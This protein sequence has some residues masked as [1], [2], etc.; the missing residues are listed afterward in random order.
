M[1]VNTQ[2]T[3]IHNLTA[4]MSPY[5]DP[6][7]LLRMIDFQI[8]LVSPIYDPETLQDERLNILKKLDMYEEAWE[9]ECEKRHLPEDTEMD[10]EYQ[11]KLDNFNDKLDDYIEK[12]D[13]IKIKL[14][15]DNVNELLGQQKDS[16]RQWI[17]LKEDHGFLEED[18]DILFQSSR[19]HYT[20]GDFEQSSADQY[21]YTLLAPYHH[22]KRLSSIWGEIGN[23][24]EL[25]EDSDQSLD[26]FESAVKLLQQLRETIDKKHDEPLKTLQ[27]RAW[28]LH[29]ALFIYFSKEARENSLNAKSNDEPDKVTEFLVN[30]CLPKVNEK[31]EKN[32]YQN[33][34]ETICPWILRYLAVIIVTCKNVEK[35]NFRLRIL[36]NMIKQ[37]SYTYNDPITDFLLC[38][39]K[40]YD[41]DTAQ[42]HLTDAKEV[43]RTDYFLHPYVDQFIENGRH[44][45][46][47]MFCRIHKKIKVETI[48]EKLDM[49]HEDAELWIV[50]LIRDARLHAKIDGESGNIIMGSDPKMPYQQIIEKTNNLNV[51]TQMLIKNLDKKIK[52]QQDRNA[53]PSWAR[54]G[55]SGSNRRGTTGSYRD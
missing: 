10:E 21:L 8:K 54:H 19:M 17:V 30:L 22:S 40:E 44:Q 43:L 28:L 38:L 16:D 20:S 35:K 34:I 52:S 50:E 39:H 36:V 3:I 13:G 9:L 25:M 27:L 48:A 41:F 46:F 32:Q 31:D 2:K 18:L 33:A 23:C 42:K 15:Q 49:T 5:L 11:S 53:V 26:K 55:D 37:E 51:S 29:W 4:K 24:I 14:K 45:I 6:C 1:S 12:V 47:E 7:Q